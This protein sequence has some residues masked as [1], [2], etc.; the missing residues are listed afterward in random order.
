[1]TTGRGR[2]AGRPL[3]AC[4]GRLCGQF[5]YCHAEVIRRRACSGK[6]SGVFGSLLAISSAWVISASTVSKSS[7]DA[8]VSQSVRSTLS[9]ACS[10]AARRS[11]A[12]GFF[13]PSGSAFRIA[14]TSSSGA[15]GS[16]CD[17]Q[18][19]SVTSAQPTAGPP[20]APGRYCSVC[21]SQEFPYHRGRLRH[22]SRH[23]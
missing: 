4:S 8:R 7:A 22:N 15:T 13:V 1:M 17:N 19:E 14:D 2:S 20:T 21:S 3:A 23:P 18:S 12:V 16:S 11:S 10:A 6:S 9:N 5:C